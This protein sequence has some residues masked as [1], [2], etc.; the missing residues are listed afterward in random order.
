M[1]SFIVVIEVKFV[2]FVCALVDFIV[3]TVSNPY[4]FRLTNAT[5]QV[6]LSL[7]LINTRSILVQHEVR[8]SFSV[9]SYFGRNET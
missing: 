5:G 4:V 6:N 2:I 9:P 1:H 8:H 3:H 7:P